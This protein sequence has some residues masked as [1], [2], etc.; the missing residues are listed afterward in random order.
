MSGLR[1][2]PGLRQFLKRR[3]FRSSLTLS[4]MRNFAR[5]IRVE[6]AA[7]DEA[8][9]EALHDASLGISRRR[10]PVGL[11]AR[12]VSRLRGRSWPTGFA[13]L[14]PHSW[15]PEV[16]SDVAR[17]R[18][19]NGQ[20]SAKGREMHLCPLQF[21]IVDR[22]IRRFSMAGETVFDPFGGVMT[23]PLRAVIMG[24]RG[25]AVELSDDYFADGVTILREQD[26]RRQTASLFDLIEAENEPDDVPADLEVEAA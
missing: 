20:L 12:F 7:A 1:H 16:W 10:R 8:N 15:H 25:I 11:L 21:D 14:P 2:Q 13:L 6:E 24:R 23:V 9:I 5:A 26:A 22:L 19:L 4:R 18:T 17:M 3:E